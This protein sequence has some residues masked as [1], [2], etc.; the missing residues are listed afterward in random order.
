V[1][2]NTTGIVIHNLTGHNDQV[3][4]CVMSSSGKYIVSCSED[5][6]VK[7]MYELDGFSYIMN[8]LDMGWLSW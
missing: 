6:T 7:V 8:I 3:T 2:Q 1:W 5:C 4:H